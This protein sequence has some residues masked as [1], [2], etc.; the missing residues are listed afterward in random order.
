MKN[1]FLRLTISFMILFGMTNLMAN[2]TKVDIIFVMDTSGSLN[3]EAPA[4][5]SAIQTV[6]Q[7]LAIDYDLDTKLWSITNQF[8]FSNAGF[9]SSVINE[10]QNHTTNHYEDWGPATYDIATYYTNWRADTIKIVVP[11]SDEGP[12]NGN[13]LYQDDIDSINAARIALDSTNIYAVPIIAQGYNQNTLYSD[14]GLILSDKA[15]K[16][17]SGDLVEQFKTI[18]RDLVAEASGESI[19]SMTHRFEENFGFGGKL[20]I[21]AKGA[22]RYDVLVKFDGTTVLDK[23]TTSSSTSVTFPANYD[24]SITHNI[25]IT[26][27]AYAVDGND[28]VL[29][30]KT[31]SFTH[32]TIPILTYQPIYAKLVAGTVAPEP[33]VL[34]GAVYG[35]QQQVIQ[36]SSVSD[37]V[38]ISSGT[39]LYSH[40]DLIVST[41]G[42]P[43]IV[44]RFYNSL[45]NIRGWKFNLISTMDISD[46]DNIKVFWEEG[47][48]E[49]IFAKAKEGWVSIYSTDTL[50]TEA[51]F[52]V[53]SKA[54]GTKYKFN[55]NG[56]LVQIVNKQDLGITFEYQGSTI[57]IKDTFTN[58]LATI[59]RNVA[60]QITSITD[61][62]GNI[63][64]YT[65]NGSNLI[66][67]TNRNGYVETYA[68]NGDL[69][70]EISGDDGKVYVSNTYDAQGRV[71][72]QQDGRGNITTFEYTGD[73]A[74]YIIT[75][76]KVTYPDGVERTHSFNLLLPTSIE[77]SGTDVKF[78][79]DSN[80][81]VK[82][83]TDVNDKEWTYERDESGLVTRAIDPQGNATV[84]AYDIN[85]NIVSSTNA[86]NQTTLFEYD[87]NANLTKVTNADGKITLYE[88]NAS[89][90]LVKITNALGGILTYTYNVS[91]KVATITSPNG[92]ITSYIYDVRGNVLSITDA[93]NRVVSY[94]YDNA[95]QVTKITN[96][97]G[98]TTK[99]FYNSFGDLIQVTD[100]KDRSIFM[101]YNVDGLLTKTILVDGTT[102]ESTYDVLGRVISS[103][104]ILGRESKKE[105]DDF[106]RVSK[107][108]DP[109]GNEFIF[110]YDNVGNLIKIVDAKGNDAQTTYDEL[111]RPSKS[112]DANGVE[113]STRTYNALSMVT[114][115]TDAT[116]KSL[117]FSFDALNRLEESTLSGYLSAKAL[118]DD[119]GRII[120]VTD[121]KDAQNNYEYDVVGNLVKETNPLSKETIYSYDI[122]GRVLTSQLPNGIVTSFEYDL[123]DRITK[124]IQTKNG[125]DTV[126][127]YTYDEV[128]NLL[129]TANA[130]GTTTYTYTINDQVAQ[131]TDIFGNTVSYEYDV[132]GRLTRL[133]YP[134]TKAIV[135]S[136]DINDNLVKV[137]DFANR[138]TLF[139]YDANS[140]LTK[141]THPNSAYTKYT[142][143]KNNRL[144]TLKNYNINNALISANIL[145]RNSIGNIVD[146]GETN[147]TSIDLSKIK[148]FNF[149]VNAFN[150]VVGSD[151]GI[152]TYDDNGNL[153]TYIYDTK[154]ITLDYDVSDMLTKA[155]I[156]NTVYDYMYDAEGNR[157]EVNSKRYIIDNVLG[158]SKPLAEV[159]AQNTITKYYVWTNGLGYSIDA[160][161]EI[162]V[163]MYDYQGNTNAVLDN[164][165]NLQASYRYTSYGTLIGSDGNIDNPFKYLGKYGIQSDSDSL[166]Y[167]RARYYSPELNRWTQA[168]V[169]RGSIASPLSLNRY[170]LNEG[171]VVN[172]ID[173]NGLNKIAIQK[174]DGAIERV[175]DIYADKLAKE[176]YGSESSIFGCGGAYRDNITHSVMVSLTSMYIRPSVNYVSGVMES[177]KNLLNSDAIDPALNIIPVGKIL[178]GK[179]LLN[180]LA[181]YKD[182]LKSPSLRKELGLTIKEVKKI[183]SDL[184]RKYSKLG[185]KVI[186]NTL[187]IYSA[188]RNIYV[189]EKELLFDKLTAK[190]YGR[191]NK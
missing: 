118:Y 175:S 105:Y 160:N 94:E 135:Y 122:V 58:L 110:E 31:D 101:E 129:T 13:G 89:N 55:T 85:K 161:G 139:E 124:T 106:G 117:S 35:P 48:S 59:T 52:Y 103:K 91:G 2:N 163:Y 27:T 93:L 17:G 6:S 127:T 32:S 92:A 186:E 28:Q 143:D 42:V 81:K 140:N 62:T 7:D 159:D 148:N 87:A 57:I 26:Y 73:L 49:D 144:A 21:D 24:K 168:D 182:I 111:Y 51:G 147:P 97:M 185:N 181:K 115:I 15:I 178:K 130:S 174:Y 114:K 90:Q 108:V 177:D 150:Q 22:G 54:N 131:R 99:M 61:A 86:L 37:P 29:D 188:Y 157:V 16:T 116:G 14:Y 156:G 164:S 113:V 45:D 102:V 80:N 72:T 19:G 74:N 123:L 9:D 56:Q 40:N 20:I 10:I 38:V 53:V 133:I 153:L 69:I 11:I 145:T 33:I 183:R 149:D 173:V 71:I 100:A 134:D 18:I 112:L 84:Y 44:K 191:S 128:G 76:A 5:I 170:V 155:T 70:T 154:N 82:T 120:K 23:T 88:Y 151:E 187:G 146:K 166:Y 141:I 107:A 176:C 1:L 30:Q 36:S 77:G 64:N 8:D 180:K 126:I 47:N 3:N 132:V 78:D 60:S 12:Q 68:Y 189:L 50:T 138:E 34:S 119:L 158:L 169:K 136:Y 172:Y 184:F 167:V 75:S 25:V 66:S 79:Y 171:D 104:D 83:I 63:I 121:P 43:L 4:L 46:I 152:F 165:N 125:I 162:L 190:V 137:I 96:P 41:S 98:Y 95:N 142:Y 109:Q 179:L 67:Y 65:Y 39:F